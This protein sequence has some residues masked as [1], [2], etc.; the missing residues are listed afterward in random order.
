MWQIALSEASK[1]A[2]SLFKGRFRRRGILNSL[3]RQVGRN[4]AAIAAL[5]VSVVVMARGNQG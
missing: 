1:N 3:L 2:K 4:L 5:E